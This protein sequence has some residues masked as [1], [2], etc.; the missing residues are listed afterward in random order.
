M[1]HKKNIQSVLISKAKYKTLAE[2]K[3]KLIEAG[4]IYKKHDITEQYYRFRQRSPKLF[5]P[6]TFRTITLK[7]YKGM[8]IIIGIRK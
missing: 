2:A 8:K 5:N 4:F 7:K 6:K 3:K 1:T